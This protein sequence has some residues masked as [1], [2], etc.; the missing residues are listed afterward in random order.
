MTDAATIQTL[1]AAFRD[2]FREFT[3]TSDSE[4]DRALDEARHIHNIRQVV[5]LYVAAHILTIRATVLAGTTGA[6]GAVKSDR[7]GPLQTNYIAL[8]KDGDIR[9]ELARTA[10]GARALLLEGRTARARIGALVAG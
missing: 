10:Y 5:T 1:R 6:T 7:V 9:A 3:T 4:L 8:A 2:Q